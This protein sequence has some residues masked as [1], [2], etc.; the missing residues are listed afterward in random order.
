M[1]D[2]LKARISR[3]EIEKNHWKTIAEVFRDDAEDVALLLNDAIKYA[4]LGHTGSAMAIVERAAEGFTA[5]VAVKQRCIR[6]MEVDEIIQSWKA[7]VESAEAERDALRKELQSVNLMCTTA[8]YIAHKAMTKVGDVDYAAAV[9]E[10]LETLEQAGE[11][12]SP[13]RECTG[14]SFSEVREVRNE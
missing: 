9:R 12:D 13:D 4:K 1:S 11:T 6:Q 10:V 7:R 8:L 3:L 14:T 2:D 5:E